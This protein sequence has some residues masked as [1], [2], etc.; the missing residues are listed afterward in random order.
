MVPALVPL[1][2]GMP[3]GM[4]LAV[5]FLRFIIFAVPIGLVIVGIALLRS[6]GGSSADPETH[7]PT[8]E[9]RL[10]RLEAQ[11]DAIQASLESTRNQE[12]DSSDPS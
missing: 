2:F 6:R 3:G 4:E 8:V 12:S 11:L 10:D 1:Q 5:L 7:D 9:E